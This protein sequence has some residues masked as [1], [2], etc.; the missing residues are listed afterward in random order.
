MLFILITIALAWAYISIPNVYVQMIV[1]SFLA[2]NLSRVASSVHLLF[3]LFS[4]IVL[5]IYPE[6]SLPYKIFLFGVLLA[7]FNGPLHGRS[8]SLI[9]TAGGLAI[10]IGILTG[11]YN[12]IA[13]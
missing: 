2:S 12:F 10:I 4:I 11:L 13:N 1:Y 6:F 5:C 9:D 3:G 8:S 7:T